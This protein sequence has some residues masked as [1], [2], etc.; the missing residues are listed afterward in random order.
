[1]RDGLRQRLAVEF[2]DEALA[3]VVV[4]GLSEGLIVQLHDLAEGGLGGSHLLSY[5]LPAASPLEVDS[6]WVFAY[7]Y[8]FG[9]DPVGPRR[10]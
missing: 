5:T 7:G 3:S 6:I 1:M 10:A 2:G 8:R 4:D 9:P